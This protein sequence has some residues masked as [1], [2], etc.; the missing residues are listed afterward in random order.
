MK[1]SSSSVIT[2][3]D[4]LTNKNFDVNCAIWITDSND[5]ETILWDGYGNATCPEDLLTKP[6]T[7]ITVRNNHLVLEAWR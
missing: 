5:Q 1:N 2:I 3:G 7:Y 6:L 4:I